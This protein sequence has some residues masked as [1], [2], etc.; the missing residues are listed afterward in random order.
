MKAGEFR[1]ICLFNAVKYGGC[2]TGILVLRIISR[3]GARLNLV[4][5]VI[6]TDGFA[7]WLKL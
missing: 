3:V 4:E 6:P 1:P 5:G 2:R 7:T